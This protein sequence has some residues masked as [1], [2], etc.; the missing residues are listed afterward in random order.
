MT[1]KRRRQKQPWLKE[2]PPL[3]AIAI[4]SAVLIAIIILIVWGVFFYEG[5]R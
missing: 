1:T 5:T 4:F 3:W 2:E